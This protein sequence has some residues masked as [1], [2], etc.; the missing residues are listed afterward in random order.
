MKISE[1]VSLILEGA[2]LWAK[3]VELSRFNETPLGRQLTE[4]AQDKWRFWCNHK[5]DYIVNA[6][7][8]MVIIA[9]EFAQ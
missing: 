3:W 2:A 8:S 7:R 1:Q 4:Q 5:D 6:A 9:K